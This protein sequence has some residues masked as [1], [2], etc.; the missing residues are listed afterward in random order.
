[1][2]TK[3]YAFFC[4]EPLWIGNLTEKGLH[5]W[6]SPKW[7]GTQNE[8]LTENETFTWWYCRAYVA[9]IIR[10]V[11]DWQLDLLDRTQLHTITVY[12]LLQLTTTLAESPHC[13]FTGCLS[14]NTWLGSHSKTDW[15]TGA[16][17]EYSLFCILKTRSLQLARL[18]CPVHTRRPTERGWLLQLALYSMAGPLFGS[19]MF[20]AR[21]S[22]ILFTSRP[23]YCLRHTLLLTGCHRNCCTQPPY[24]L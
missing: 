17:P 24:C 10:R 7:T 6:I 4:F 16:R 15:L 1:M 2:K 14:S 23:P 3:L 13:V 18:D 22:A 19:V 9:T 21:A 5:I 20:T 12:T 8:L 11:L